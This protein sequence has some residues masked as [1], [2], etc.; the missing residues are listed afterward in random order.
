MSRIR[1]RAIA[2]ASSAAFALVLASALASADGVDSDQD[3]VSDELE[4]ATQ[5]T[6]AATAS[7]DQFNVS[8]YLGTNAV[9]DHFEFSYWKGHFGVLYEVDDG[10]SVA[11]DLELRSLL[12]W[13][14][15]DR[16]G[17]IEEVE[18]RERIPL[19]SSA[20]G[21]ANVTS[22]PQKDTDGGRVFNFAMDSRDGQ[23]SLNVA[24]AQ[25]YTRLADVTLTPMEARMDFQMNHALSYPEASLGLELL[26]ETS[27]PDVRFEDHNWER[28]IVPRP[29]ERAMIVTGTEDGRSASAFFSW[30]NDAIVSEQT[31][32]VSY[33][34]Q[35]LGSNQYSLFFPYPGGSLQA[36]PAVGH[37]MAFGVLSVAHDAREGATPFASVLQGDL[38]LFTGTFAGMTGLVALTIFL[39][40]RRR[41]RREDETRKA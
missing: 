39:S 17:R 29:S 23:V 14:D 16:N 36:P 3:G 18:I 27:R 38:F 4:D 34:S 40:S 35:E 24:V 11:Y 32:T 6:V 37:Q 10:P 20:F 22:S 19:G 13:R 33:S 9:R 12:E 41:V 31:T 2:F 1:S 25:R 21:G 5:R 28:T 26:L 8:S 30:A 7:G 15:D